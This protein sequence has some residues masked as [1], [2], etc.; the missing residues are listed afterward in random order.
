MRLIKK[1]AT[2]LS[3]LVEDGL[4]RVTKVLKD[5][6]MHSFEKNLI[7]NNEEIEKENEKIKK[8]KIKRAK[9][10]QLIINENKD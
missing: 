5:E 10:K 2:S 9:R 6:A 3:D 7:M 4:D 1:L 8:R